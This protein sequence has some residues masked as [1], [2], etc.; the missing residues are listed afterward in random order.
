MLDQGNVAA[1]GAASPLTPAPPT[2]EGAAQILVNTNVIMTV[3]P[4]DRVSIIESMAITW[5]RVMKRSEVNARIALH[6]A[7]QLDMVVMT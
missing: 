2:P 3:L 4:V 6:V 7:R 1:P 5:T